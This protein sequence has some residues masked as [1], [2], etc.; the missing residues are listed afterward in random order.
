MGLEVL[1]VD[2]DTAKVNP[3]YTVHLEG[4]CTLNTTPETRK[5]IQEHPRAAQ[6][7][8]A[9]KDLV[10][11]FAGATLKLRFDFVH[12]DTKQMEHH[13]ATGV[14]V[15]PNLVLTVRHHLFHPVLEKR[16]DYVVREHVLARVDSD[17]SRMAGLRVCRTHPELYKDPP[18]WFGTELNWTDINKM[19]S[20]IDPMSTFRERSA[21]HWVWRDFVFL[22]ITTPTD[23]LLPPPYFLPDTDVFTQEPVMVGGF[24]V[25]EADPD[26]LLG[27]YDSYVR[28]YQQASK[29]KRLPFFN[30]RAADTWPEF[31]HSMFHH[32]P[33]RNIVVSLGTVHESSSQRLGLYNGSAEVGMAGG[34]VSPIVEAARKHDVT[35]PLWGIHAGRFTDGLH[36]VFLSVEHPLFIVQY[37]YT[38]LTHF[39]SEPQYDVPEYVEFKK[40]L[41]NYL[42]YFDWLDVYCDNLRRNVHSAL[43]K[44]QYE[45]LS[46]LPPP[47]DQTAVAFRGKEELEE[48][49]EEAATSLVTPKRKREGGSRRTKATKTKKA[50]K[51]NEAEEEESPELDTTNLPVLDDMTTD[52]LRLELRRR[53]QRTSGAK[54]ELVARLRKA[55]EEGDAA[56]STKR[57][58]P[59]KWGNLKAMSEDEGEVEHHD[60]EKKSEEESEE[61][62]E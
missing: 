29:L 19:P 61:E 47:K 17:N 27:K 10:K 57:G 58:Q 5:D 31:V 12:K 42:N 36:N 28:V 48:V 40:R 9:N 14:A 51:P 21:E 43:A 1:Q 23:L 59:P 56:T 18:L 62:E 45:E 52:Q 26:R 35:L 39:L 49:Q 30:S 32:Y 16:N 46:S 24:A 44:S 55:R 53:G 54:N 37:A 8:K 13:F 6:L 25:G 50:K 4:E 15:A 34:P 11:G 7:L 2:V 20:D 38:M 3:T 41:W 22:R 60:N 33:K